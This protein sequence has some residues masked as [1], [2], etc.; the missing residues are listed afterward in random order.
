MIACPELA[1]GL[2]NRVIATAVAFGM[3]RREAE[4]ARVNP[5]VR[6]HVA[7]LACMVWDAAAGDKPA[8]RALER[9]AFAFGNRG[10]IAEMLDA[11]EQ[12]A[13]SGELTKLLGL[14]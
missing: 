2:T 8:K 14:D 9:I 5:Y 12:P 6:A 3:P 11:H 7:M 13:D 1:P 4:E 10:N